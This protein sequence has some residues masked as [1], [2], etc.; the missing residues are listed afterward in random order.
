MPPQFQLLKIKNVWQRL[1]VIIFA[2][3]YP[4]TIIPCVQLLSQHW[5]PDTPAE[6]SE[7]TFAFITDHLDVEKLEP[8]TLKVMSPFIVF[9]VHC[10]VFLFT[11]WSIN[12]NT[13]LKYIKVSD[14]KIATHVLFIPKGHR[15]TPEIVKFNNNA[16]I[17]FAIFQ[18]KKREYINGEFH[19]LKYPSD[20]PISEYLESKGLTKEE[21]KSRLDYFGPNS[22]QIP[23]PSFMELMKEH[24]LAPFFVFQ[25]FSILCWML[26]EYFIYSLFSLLA[27]FIIEANTVN[28]RQSNL[29]ELRGVENEPVKFNVY[30]DGQW[31]SVFNDKLVPGDIILLNSNTEGLVPADLLL[32]T[33]RCVTNEAMLTGEST[34]QVKDS[35]SSLP[36]DHRLNIS[37]D[38]KY[39]LFG[40]TKIEQVVPSDAPNYI[41]TPTKGCLAY[42]LSTG[43]GSSQGRLIRTILFASQRVS[44][45][46][47][48]SMY[49]LGFLSIFAII[50]SGY[51]AWYGIQSKSISTFRIIV[52]CLLILTSSIPPDLP[53]ELTFSVNASLLALSKLTVFCTEPFRIPFAGT[54]SVCCFDKT[55]TLTA[56]DF[57][58]VGIDEIGKSRNPTTENATKND[59]SKESEGIMGNY[60]TDPTILTEESVMVVGGCQSLMMGNDGKLIGDSL[61]ATSFKA[62]GFSLTSATKAKLK[63][64]SITNHKTF[65][66]SADLR[67][68]STISQIQKTG[69]KGG[70]Y[71]VL[72]KG[73]PEVIAEHLESIPE[74][75]YEVYRSYT[76]QGCRVLALA[77]RL[78]DQSEVSNNAP[79]FTSFTRDQAEENL[80][81][82]GFEIFSS[83]MKR[84][85]EDTIVELLKSTHRVVMITGDDPLTA[86]HVATRLHIVNGKKKLIIHDD[87]VNDVNGNPAPPES[88]DLKDNSYAHCYT[89]K[90]ITN[91][92]DKELS[93][94]VKKCNVFARMS[95]QNKEDVMFKLKKLG[96]RTLMCGDGTNDVGALKQAHVGVGVIE[97]SIDVQM[98]DDEY[99]PKLGAVSIAAPFVAKKGTIS[100][101][102]DLIRFGR[103]TLSSTIDLFKQL[104]LNC[105]ISAF[106]MSVLFVENVKFGDQQMTSFAVGISVASMA[107]TWAKPLRTLSSERPFESQFSLYLVTTVLIQFA[108]HLF[109][110]NSAR[111]LVYSTGYEKKPFDYKVKFQPNLMNT[112][113]F[114]LTNEMQITTFIANYRGRPFMQSFFE[115]KL[116]FFSILF[117]IFIMCLLFIDEPLFFK[118]FQT[119]PFPSV[120]FRN[121]IAVYC[122]ADLIVSVIIEKVC[123]F[124]FTLKNKFD[125]KDLVDPDVIKDLKTYVPHNDDVIPEE[126]H[127][128]GV[129]DLFKQNIDLQMKMAIRRNQIK[130]EETINSMKKDRRTRKLATKLAKK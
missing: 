7:G 24:V 9:G 70:T 117:S 60:Q 15:G 128:F 58:L 26:D 29:L 68:M 125:S 67:R 76:R 44:A 119:V 115:N 110:L 94:V 116:L 56:E 78:L 124:L 87:E 41:Y 12:F 5:L 104:S 4:I 25:V 81:F 23:I 20:C 89:G 61:E 118:L 62:L 39:I 6:R 33:G 18:Q 64:L 3:L 106:T 42:V 123:L 112:V 55:G 35:A 120:D 97:N 32:L 47:R 11:Y 57:Q 38:T 113:M 40:G 91:M 1:D 127:K 43:L 86:C 46:S 83:P 90:A 92:D 53:M 28:T 100:A 13:F 2:I 75:Y 84:G 121:K 71:Y 79:N 130:R 80:N 63:T 105:M 101:C 45:E 109:I 27:L 36:K 88:L 77:S 50:A 59:E 34:P 37:R 69:G 122:A 96:E 82:A 30:R 54:V 85:T 126:K 103:A 74:N 21:S 65:H 14:E 107:I 102:I 51:I 98:D 17:P 95:P 19:P 129:K 99:H 72:A 73:A 108:F 8:Y 22:Y 10:V 114:I 48:D 31:S 93:E 52:E 16:P 66:F 49:L 111:W